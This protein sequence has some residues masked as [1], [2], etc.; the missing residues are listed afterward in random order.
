MIIKYVTCMTNAHTQTPWPNN[1]ILTEVIPS[2]SKDV[3][4]ND[5]DGG[6]QMD[7]I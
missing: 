6:P 5:T 2:P 1:S 7:A 4:R 3:Y